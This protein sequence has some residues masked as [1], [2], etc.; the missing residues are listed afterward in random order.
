MVHFHEEEG[1]KKLSMFQMP[2]S[3]VRNI[4]QK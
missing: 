3:I 2:I 1:Y 4:I